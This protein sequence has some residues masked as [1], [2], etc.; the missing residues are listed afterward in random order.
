MTK[1][2]YFELCETL[3]SEP[4]DEEIPIELDD[5]PEIVQLT[6]SIYETLQDEWEYMG[7]NYVGKKLQ[8]LVMLF[9]LYEIPRE[10]HLLVYKFISIID[11]VR[12]EIMK[13]KNKS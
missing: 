10:E 1:D 8:N 6:F 9:D 11:S 13:S 2:Q 4:L 12:K 7:G 5:L 3:G